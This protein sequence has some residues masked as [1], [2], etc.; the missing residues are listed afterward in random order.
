[1]VGPA[2]DASNVLDQPTSTKIEA[3]LDEIVQ[4]VAVFLLDRD[5]QASH[6]LVI[7]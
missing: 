4:H 7:L 6:A 3:G 2:V 1:M 5:S